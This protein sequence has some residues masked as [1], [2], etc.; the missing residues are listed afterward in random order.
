M[1]TYK[2][3]KGDYQFVLVRHTMTFKDPAEKP[4]W[5]HEVFIRVCEGEEIVT[6]YYNSVDFAPY[7]RM[8][9][10]SYQ[11]WLEMDQPDRFTV[12]L[13]GPL[14]NSII[15]QLYKQRKKK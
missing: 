10:S 11:K 8:T 12:K 13:N 1:T 15:D 2:P 9:D 14:T 6:E 3:M 5:L 7:E 4:Q